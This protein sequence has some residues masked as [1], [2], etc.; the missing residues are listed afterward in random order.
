M[1]RVTALVIVVTSL[2]GSCYVGQSGAGTLKDDRQMVLCSA[3]ASLKDDGIDRENAAEII[4]HSR[5]DE[6]Q[7]E[8]FWR[9]YNGGSK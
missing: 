2:I 5:M 9:C 8:V 1:K 4:S 3:A 7:R 6:E